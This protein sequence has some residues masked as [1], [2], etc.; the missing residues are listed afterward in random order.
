MASK[1]AGWATFVLIAVL[2]GYMVVAAVG[3]LVML[4]EMAATLGLQV[5]AVGW[6]WLWLGVV[7]PLIGFAVALLISRRRKGGSKL[8]I[9]ATGLAVVAALQLEIG[10]LVPPVSFFV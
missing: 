1:I 8:L 7:L 4:P 6:F 3:N 2:Y 10:L 5:N 9:L